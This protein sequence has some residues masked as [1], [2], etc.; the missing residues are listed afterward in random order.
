MK[1]NHVW[2]VKQTLNYIK[3][4]DKYLLVFGNKHKEVLILNIYKMRLIN[5]INN[6][7]N[8]KK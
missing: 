8:L 3:F 4:K 5:D 7:T 1:T 2:E 6:K